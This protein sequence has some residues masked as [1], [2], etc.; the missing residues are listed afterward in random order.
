M[1][2]RGGRVWGSGAA[3]GPVSPAGGQAPGGAVGHPFAAWGGME[4]CDRF[5]VGE[6]NQR[7]RPRRPCLGGHDLHDPRPP[8]VRRPLTPP[9][10]V[11]AAAGRQRMWCRAARRTP[12]S[13]SSRAAAT[14]P[15][16]RPRRAPT[17][18]RTCPRR[19]CAADALHG[20]DRGP[21]HQ[22]APC[23]VIR[24]RCT[25][26]SD[27]WCFGVSPAQ[28]GQLRGSVEAG[29]V[30]DLGD[31]HRG[32]DRPDPGDGLD[33]QVAGIGAQPAGDQLGEQ[34]DLEV[35]RGD[36]P[37]QRVDPGPGLRR[38]PRPRPAAAAR[39]RRTG[40]SSAPAP[41]R[42][43]ARRGP[44]TS[45]STAARPA[46]PGAA[47]SRAAPG[48]P[49]G[50][51]TPRAAGPSAADRPGPRRRVRRSSPAAARTSSPPAGAPDAPCAPSSA[52]V[53]AAQYQP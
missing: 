35:Q 10:R 29:D 18:S 51:S 4:C 26:V 53:S 39:P 31:E 44:G 28:R 52:S 13:V 43:R 27:S 20:L 15:M 11:R 7:G 16:L 12:A 5:A 40:R 49:A 23:L 17:R 46:S 33:R 42:R 24:P 14:T 30:A 50:R 34:L 38:Q 22:P 6:I 21:A 19:V 48:S 9:A 37:Q 36:Q 8:R 45:G 2:L 47:P 3:P 25:V 41:R 32:Q 1:R